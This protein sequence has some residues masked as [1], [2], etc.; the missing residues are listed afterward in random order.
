MAHR[1]RV[2]PDSLVPGELS[3]GGHDVRYLKHV[4][5]LRPGDELELFDGAGRIAS[6]RVVSTEADAV[7]VEL[8]EPRTAPVPTHSLMLLCA[9]LKGDRMELVLQKATELGVTALQP[10]ES[11]RTVVKLGDRGSK[12]HARWERVITGA[13]RQSGR[14]DVPGLAPPCSWGEALERLPAGGVRVLCH[15]GASDAGLG[16][17]GQR[18]PTVVAVGPEGGFT[19]DEVALG[20]QHGFGVAGLGPRVLRAETAAIVAVTLAAHRAGALG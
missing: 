6:A 14:A 12:R 18:A 2:S 9:I 4:L 19:P 8:G 7:T 5:R 1:L 17:I 11:E 13:A 15:E 10:F 16:S 20:R 3:L